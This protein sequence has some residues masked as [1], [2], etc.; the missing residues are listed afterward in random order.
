DL[1]PRIH[2]GKLMQEVARA[3]GGTGGGR[4]D[5]AQGGAKDDSR[6]SELKARVLAYVGGRGQ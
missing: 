4:P 3:V 6:L 5:L 1:T 2:A